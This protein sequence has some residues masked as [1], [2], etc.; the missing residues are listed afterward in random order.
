MLWVKEVQANTGLGY[1]DNLVLGKPCCSSRGPGL[2][3]QNPYWIALTGYNYSSSAA[4]HLLWNNTHVTYTSINRYTY[5]KIT[6]TKQKNTQP[7]QKQ[8]AMR[9]TRTHPDK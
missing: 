8:S 9:E 1:R 2:W 7:L 5:M 6:L 4:N 3:S